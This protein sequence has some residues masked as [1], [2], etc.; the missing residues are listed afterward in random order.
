MNPVPAAAVRTALTEAVACGDL[1]VRIP[2][3][4][5]VRRSRFSELGDFATPVA[6]TLAGEAG[7]SPWAVAAVLAGKL[8]TTA[9]I[10]GVDI[11]GP[12]FVNIR[13]EAATAGTAGAVIGA[14][15]AAGAAY[16]ASE[17]ATDGTIEI[18]SG[19]LGLRPVPI[20]DA[21]RRIESAALGR[22]ARTQKI[23]VPSESGV[24]HR[25]SV[26]SQVSTVRA[27]AMS[28]PGPV[29]LIWKRRA[30]S[31]AVRSNRVTG[32]GEL[33]DAVGVDAARF[34]LLRSPLRAGIELEVQVWAAQTCS[35][36]VYRVR[37]AHA[38]LAALARSVR[39]LGIST[40]GNLPACDEHDPAL[41]DT[42][43]DTALVLLIA[44]YP[45]ILTAAARRTEPHPVVR[46][47]EELSAAAHA[48]LDTARVLP[49]GDEPA[50]AGTFARI[51]LGAAVQQVL[52]NGLAVLDVSAPEQL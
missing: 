17:A 3:S 5:S 14:V 45:H 2:D 13:L 1:A 21:R 39:D 10:S 42:P 48:H 37:F 47:L 8:R 15:L 11:S 35:S 7:L 41:L 31:G 52:A 43:A 23:A 28:E 32:F 29:L 49:T 9:G 6:L 4:I 22:I 34:A 46:Y 19:D 44:D 12:G 40:A 30:Q 50:T 36:P 51:R 33:V 38:R 18:D 26:D 24:D 20:A 25:L 27:G 16:G